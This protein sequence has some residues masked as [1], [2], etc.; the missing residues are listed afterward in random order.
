MFGPAEP[1]PFGVPPPARAVLRGRSAAG[2]AGA[3][4]SLSSRFRFVPFPFPSSPES[5]LESDPEL[6]ESLSESL[7]LFSGFAPGELPFFSREL[8]L[9]E[10]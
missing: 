9:S 4:S 8:S 2:V 3:S 10:D 6:D 1:L 7:S 5:E